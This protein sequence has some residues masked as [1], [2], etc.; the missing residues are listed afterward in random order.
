MSLITFLKAQFMFSAT[1]V[2]Q[3]WLFWVI[4]LMLWGLKNWAKAKSNG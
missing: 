1:G 4:V 2:S 3:S